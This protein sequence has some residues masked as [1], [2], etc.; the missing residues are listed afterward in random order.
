MLAGKEYQIL[1]RN[2]TGDPEKVSV[3]E[4]VVFI[5]PIKNILAYE[6]YAEVLEGICESMVR[7]GKIVARSPLI[8]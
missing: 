3:L 7:S 1:H 6:A 2:I 4:R 8:A 5:H